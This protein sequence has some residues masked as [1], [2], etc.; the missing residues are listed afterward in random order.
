MRFAHAGKIGGAILGPSGIFRR[1]RHNTGKSLFFSLLAGNSRV[2][3]GSTTTASAT[4]QINRLDPVIGEQTAHVLQRALQF[5]SRF[6]LHHRALGQLHVATQIVR[7]KDC[8][9]VAQAVPGERRDLRNRRFG[10]R[11][12]HHR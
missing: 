1:L 11:Q 4:N 2:E 5:C 12:T 10:E 3:R 9:D 7:I 8:L 6:E